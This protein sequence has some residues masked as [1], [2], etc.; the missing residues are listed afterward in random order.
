MS[1]V[2]QHFKNFPICV[3]A[4]TYMFIK[5]RFALLPH[6]NWP[7]VTFPPH[8]EFYTQAQKIHLVSSDQSTFLYF[9]CVSSIAR[10][11]TSKQDLRRSFNYDFRLATPFK[12][13]ICRVN[14]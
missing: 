1:D 3:Q 8:I 2:G 6:L 11:E 12:G 9:C 5:Q 7:S 14:K 10:K 4:T 13:Q